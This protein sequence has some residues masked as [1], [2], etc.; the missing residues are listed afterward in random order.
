MGNF[1]GGMGNKPA[2]S[3]KEEGE[4]SE[5]VSQELKVEGE[6]KELADLTHFETN[7][8]QALYERFKA[9]C[10]TVNIDGVINKDE[11]RRGLDL[12]AA[13]VF[14][15]RLFLS[16]DRSNNDV[17]D[18]R[19]F[20]LGLSPFHPKAPIEEKIKLSFQLYDLH[21]NNVITPEEL[22]EMLSEIIMS[23]PTVNMSREQIDAVVD[24]TIKEAD[25][26]GSGTISFE[27]YRMLVDKNPQMLK[28][29][30]IPVLNTLTSDFPEF[31]FNSFVTQGHGT[32]VE[33]QAAISA[34]AA[35]AQTSNSR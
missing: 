31:V 22:A 11:F 23:N 6:A 33:E 28:T 35:N 1:C 13:N 18:F 2:K 26:G 21:G 34:R 25:L 20:V 27:E 8:V 9:V 19:E 15:D 7:Q 12:P 3:K 14:V 16:F 17:I 29:M 10:S 24:S 32:T 30:T 4:T 5:N